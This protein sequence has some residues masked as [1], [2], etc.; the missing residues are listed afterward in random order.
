M[1]N[2]VGAFSRQLLNLV[3]TT[4]QIEGMS[5][6]Y[7]IIQASHN[8]P[9]VESLP[10]YPAKKDIDTDRFAHHFTGNRLVGFAISFAGNVLII[11]VSLE[12]I[13]SYI[14]IEHE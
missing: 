9:S 10:T 4:N 2:N 5:C 14:E 1:P 8:V 7:A 13:Q 11:S 12:R 6:H 3:R